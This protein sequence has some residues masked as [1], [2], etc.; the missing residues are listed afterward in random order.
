M[1]AGQFTLSSLPGRGT[2][3]RIVWQVAPDDA[4]DG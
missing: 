1:T 2:S 3:V 4:M